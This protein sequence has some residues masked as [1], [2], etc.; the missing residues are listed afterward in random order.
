[1]RKL[2][3]VPVVHTQADM[4]SLQS[5]VKREF[6]ARYGED[7]WQKLD[8]AVREFWEGLQQR[9]AQLQL[10]YPKT[11]VYQD[12]L[13]VCGKEVRIVTELAQQ[14]SR[15]HRLVLW[16]V[17]RGANLVGTESPELLLEEYDLLRKVF[18]APDAGHRTAA[19]TA[20]NERAGELLAQRDEYVRR[21]IDDT[22]PDEGVG[23]LFIGLT[24]HVDEGLPDDIRVAYL[25]HNLPFRRN[26]DI[27]RL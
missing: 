14:G 13:P 15:N 5:A 16:L 11:Y 9:I 8:E 2:I 18:S 7:D 4:G 19:A 21:R 20:Y 1:M 3:Y 23:V 17:E 6:L 27:E 24:H 22:L 10:E 26:G 25:V 12:G